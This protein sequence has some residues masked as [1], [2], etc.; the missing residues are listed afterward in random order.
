MPK[1]RRPQVAFAG[2]SNVG[3]STLL[4]KL[5]GRKKIAKVSNTPGK[6]RSLN[7]FLVNETFYFVDLPGYG[8]AKV[9]KT[10]QAG[11]GTMIESYLE[12]SE[13][14]K[15]LVFLLDCRR[16]LHEEDA[17]LLSWL[18]G[19]DLPVMIAITKADKLNRDKINRK[20][21]ATEKEL[22]LSAIAFSSL[23]GIGKQEVLQAIGDLINEK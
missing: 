17:Q 12:K 20:V 3:K 9:S 8:Y 13:S 14:L 15:G 2:R 21:Q 23:S 18:I 11:W 4:N 16:D 22:G 19:R 6:T 5:T 7:F 10:T 1:D